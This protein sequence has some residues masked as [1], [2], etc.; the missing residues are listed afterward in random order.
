MHAFELIGF[1]C[2]CV[3]IVFDVLFVFVLLKQ[4]FR[5]IVDGTCGVF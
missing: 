5:G 4:N 3:H 1:N 2:F